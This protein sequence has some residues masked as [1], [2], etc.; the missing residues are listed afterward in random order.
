MFQ[1]LKANLNAYRC[2]LGAEPLN[3]LDFI[4]KCGFFFE[5]YT[6]SLVVSVCSWFLNPIFQAELEKITGKSDCDI[7]VLEEVEG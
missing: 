1:N 5:H 4:Q 6:V 3:T 2:S 7:V